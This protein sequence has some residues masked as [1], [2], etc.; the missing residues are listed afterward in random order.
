LEVIRSIK[1]DL[2]DADINHDGR[3]CFE[4]LKLV[5]SKYNHTLSEQEI[6]EMG[7]LFFVGKSGQSIRHTTMLRGVQ[8]TAIEGDP[9]ENPL[10]LESSNDQRCWTS[11]ND[12]H[13]ALYRI[14]E[15]FDRLLMKYIQEKKLECDREPED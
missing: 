15:E 3:V 4:E 6:E 8:H 10:E 9:E 2:I 12:S 5:M 1:Q 11:Q 13:Q 14:Q 7:E